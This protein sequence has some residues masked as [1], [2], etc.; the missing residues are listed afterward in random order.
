MSISPPDRRPRRSLFPCIPKQPRFGESGRGNLPR[1]IFVCFEGWLGLGAFGL[2]GA[3]G[4]NVTKWQ[5]MRF[6]FPSPLPSGRRGCTASKKLKKKKNSPDPLWSARSSLS[7]RTSSGGAKASPPIATSYFAASPGQAWGPGRKVEKERV[8]AQWARLN[9]LEEEARVPPML[10]KPPPSSS[11]P[12]TCRE[13]VVGEL[14]PEPWE[15][16]INQFLL[17]R[18]T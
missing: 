13:S 2:H 12:R 4:R 6:P 5:K 11:S 9:L 10:S 8:F 16:V 17:M 15:P 14:P 7:G 3:W 1:E 18:I